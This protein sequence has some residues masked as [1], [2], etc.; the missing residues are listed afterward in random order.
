MNHEP[1]INSIGINEETFLVKSTLNWISRK[2]RCSLKFSINLSRRQLLLR[3]MSLP[4]IPGI[5]SK[6]FLPKRR[7]K[8]FSWAGTAARREFR[9]LK[10]IYKQ[11]SEIVFRS[12][13]ISSVRRSTT[14]WLAALDEDRMRSVSP[15]N[16]QQLLLPFWL[17]YQ[18]FDFRSVVAFSCSFAHTQQKVGPKHL[19]NFF[20]TSSNLLSTAKKH[21]TCS[22]VSAIV[23]Y[24]FQHFCIHSTRGTQ[25]PHK[26]DWTRSPPIVKDEERTSY[27]YKN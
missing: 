5:E 25:K 3:H 16:H 18:E 15:N 20:P 13:S 6:F 12:F 2:F 23:I 17:H 27:V 24:T 11:H 14:R 9:Q 7:E 19:T 8:F 1:S 10:R 22:R 4:L 21:R 26:I